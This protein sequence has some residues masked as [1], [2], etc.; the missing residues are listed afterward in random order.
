MP[1]PIDLLVVGLKATLVL[2]LAGLAA[3]SL[4]RGAAATRHLVWTLGVVA[5]LLLPTLRGFTPRWEMPLLPSSLRDRA[6]EAPLAATPVKAGSMAPT[7]ARAG[8]KAEPDPSSPVA[9]TSSSV[10]PLTI[11][12]S[13]VQPAAASPWQS[14]DA[15]SLLF[16]LWLIGVL[17]VAVPLVIAAVRVRWL[18]RRAIVLEAPAWS[19]LAAEIAASIGLTRHVRLLQGGPESMPMAWGVLHPAVLLPR[20]AEEWPETQRRS[21]LTHELAHVK[22]HDCLT[23]AIAQVACSVYWFHP[24]VWLAARRL[25]VERE[26]ACDDLVL[27]SGASGPDYADQL[28]QLARRARWSEPS[29]WTAVAM[30]RPSQLEGRLLAILD[31]SLDR[32]GPSRRGAQVSMVAAAFLVVVLAGLEPW[33]RPALAA[34]PVD[35][36]NDVA[37]ASIPSPASPTLS[38]MALSRDDQDKPGKDDPSHDQ[39][40]AQASASEVKAAEVEAPEVEAPEVESEAPEAEERRAPPPDRVVAALTGAVRDTDSEVRKEAVYA[41]GELRA[42]QGAPAL[43]SALSDQDAE[44]RSQAAFALGQIRS[45]AA[46]GPLTTALADKAPEVRQQA[47][48]ALGQI[49]ARSAVDG[50]TTALK[51]PNEEVRQ[52]AAFALGQIRDPKSV[53]ALG[54]ALADTSAEVRQQAVFALGQIR[55]EEAVTPL[56]KALKDANEEVRQQAAFALGQIRNAQSVPSLMEA[57]KDSSAEVRQQAAFALGQLGDERAAEALTAALKDAQPEVRR[58]A[59]FALGQIAK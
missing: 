5:A 48:F 22:R 25:R 23:Q 7:P 41:L 37:P 24:L 34:H 52:Q 38:K 45:E 9:D 43:A 28:L 21:V 56:S 27:R 54:A 4:R 6:P 18:G 35:V 53:A 1:T 36:A 57:L 30:A 42:P 3:G 10:A 29:M 13:V 40:Q 51:D 32:R 17:A 15:A 44:V 26:H 19:A 59:A 55:A 2:A 11:A 46:V 8:V 39:A 49:R 33:A 12:P 14:L 16:A 58:Q 31:P 47:V 20:A 50:L